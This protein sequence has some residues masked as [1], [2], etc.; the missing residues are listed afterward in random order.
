M[1]NKTGIEWTDS[2]WNPWI[3]CTR[4][5]AECDNCYAL[6]AMTRYGHDAAAVKRTKTWSDPLRWNS[7]AARLERRRK[8]FACSWSDWFHADADQWREDAWMVVRCCQNLDFLILTKRPE[9]IIECLPDDW[10]SMYFGYRNGGY[11]NAWLGV[12]VGHSDTLERIDELV[13]VPAAV[14]FVS[15]EPLLERISLGRWLWPDC[16]GTDAD[17]EAGRC[18]RS[19]PLLDWVIIGCESGPRRRPCDLDWVLE[20]VEQ[21][22]QAGVPVFVKQLSVNGRVSKDPAEWPEWARVRQFPKG[23]C[24]PAYRFSSSSF[25]SMVGGRVS[26]DPAEWPEWARVRQFPKGP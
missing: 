26:K 14:R 15:C 23:P 12:T 16:P 19:R 4:V 25:R 5:S 2:T 20:L 1:A 24:R 3:G 11:L 18:D 13:R 22:R 8:V 7:E 9:R 10:P 21:C 6:N 17:C